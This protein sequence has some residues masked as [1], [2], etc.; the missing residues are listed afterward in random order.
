MRRLCIWL[1]HRLAWI[2]RGLRR[3]DEPHYYV[4]EVC[5]GKLPQ[6]VYSTTPEEA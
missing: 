2:V 6:F 1:M 3:E 4:I 5:M